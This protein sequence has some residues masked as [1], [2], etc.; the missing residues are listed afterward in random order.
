M[1]ERQQRLAAIILKDPAVESISSFIGIDGTNLTLN[2]GRIQINLKPLE[3]RKIDASDVIRR[4]QPELARVDGINLYMQPVQDLSV[5]DRVSR[6][7]FQ[8]TLEDPNTE[9]LN[10]F[11]PRMVEGMRKLPQLRD[12]AS[13]RRSTVCARASS[14]IAGRIPPRRHRG[15]DRQHTIRRL[16]TASGIDYLHPVEPVSR[17]A[18]SE[19][20]IST[21]SFGLEQPLHSDW[22]C[23]R[24]FQRHCRRVCHGRSH[25][26]PKRQR[27]GRRGGFQHG[28]RYGIVRARHLAGV[29]PTT[30][31]TP[32]SA[33]SHL[34]SPPF[35]SPSATRVS[36]PL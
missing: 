35:R 13:D 7:Q 33:F 30:G 26:I 23:R 36:F 27:D 25:R 31:Q 29:L 34:N 1:S 8:L 10:A 32:L 24:R 20:R 21:G 18:G 3:E 6:T 19:G 22:N 14:T 12:V 11:T 4:L 2:S 15:N 17:R 5:E 16:W 28:R 9:E